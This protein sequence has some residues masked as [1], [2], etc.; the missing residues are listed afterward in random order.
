MTTATVSPKLG[1]YL[2]SEAESLLTYQ[3]KVD[4][5]HLQLPGPDFV[6]RVWMQSDRNPQ[7]MRNLQSFFDHG[8]LGGTGYMSLL[9]VDQGI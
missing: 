2:G 8:R 7:V 4:K 6:D 5:S 1:E 3:A 9:P